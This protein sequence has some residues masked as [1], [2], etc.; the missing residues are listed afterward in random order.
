MQPEDSPVRLG[1]ATKL[2]V[3][4]HPGTKSAMGRVLFLSAALALS[5]NVLAQDEE[6][7]ESLKAQI[8]GMEK[9]F[10]A[11]TKDR[12]S[13]YDQ[14]LQT[15]EEL[16]AAESKSQDVAT[17]RAH[18]LTRFNEQNAAAAAREAELL[19]Q[20]ESLEEDGDFMSER[21]Q[22]LFAETKALSAA[23]DVQQA[24]LSAESDELA[25][26]ALVQIQSALAERDAARQELAAAQG[27][28]KKLEADLQST[29][30]G[31][32]YIEGQVKSAKA[33]LVEAQSNHASAIAAAEAKAKSASNGRALTRKQLIA[34][35]EE[36]E[37]L[38][39]QLNFAQIQ[40]SKLE[41]DL[42]QV[43]VLNNQL[44]FAQIQLAKLEGDLQAAKAMSNKAAEEE[45]EE[46]AAAAV[47][48]AWANDISAELANRYRG[49]SGVSV[50]E[51]PGN[52]VGIRI[53]NAGLFSTGAS[54]L[55]DNG[56]NLLSR[57]GEAL[58][59]QTDARVLVLGHTDNV[60]VGSNSIYVDNTDLSNRRALAA[61][62]H[63]GDNVGISFN[64]MSST[65][66]ADNYPIASNENSEGRAQNRRI[67]LELSPL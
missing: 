52:R 34:A 19:A 31:R 4:K 51:L 65:G 15:I 30:N 8:A 45:A 27:A 53:G 24:E 26:V 29:I 3:E 5:A 10:D 36:A 23:A 55:S 42:G 43:D 12:N 56:R 39:N 28:S 40:M 37:A 48:A 14:L 18:I 17:G 41:G 33:E 64:R 58:R 49:I 38:K 35:K 13:L 61:M 46:K 44:N 67:E 66:L 63:L 59:Q 9:K 60:P 57:L 7:V 6:T 11:V 25:R 1:Q 22:T 54:Q 50:S 21:V 2:S 16:E 32:D 62:K 47:N 20:I